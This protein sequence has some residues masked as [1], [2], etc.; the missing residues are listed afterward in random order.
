MT[1]CEGQT[2][3]ELI[4]QDV[5]TI[6]AM[7]GQLPRLAYMVHPVDMQAML[8]AQHSQAI[9]CKWYELHCDVGCI[10]VVKDANH[11]KGSTHRFTI[12]TCGAYFL[13]FGYKST[14]S[15]CDACSKP[16]APRC[17]QCGGYCEP[18][19]EA[20][21]ARHLK[22]SPPISYAKLLKRPWVHPVQYDPWAAY[23]G[24]DR[25]ADR[26]MLAGAVLAASPRPA[27][28][29]IIDEIMR[30][31]QELAAK[32]LPTEQGLLVAGMAD[33][34]REPTKMRSDATL[35]A[36]LGHLKH[37]PGGSGL[38]GPCDDGCPKCKSETDASRSMDVEKPIDP[39]DVEYD[40]VTLRELIRQ[41]TEN[42]RHDRL[43]M[44]GVSAWK[45]T[46]DQRAAVSAHWSAE[47]RAKVAASTAVEVQSNRRRI[48]CDP[49][50][51]I[52]LED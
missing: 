2:L 6:A 5:N 49:R 50:E 12:C 37:G 47:L 24:V 52:D 45:F 7:T 8:R 36:R 38:E 41:D 20:I 17:D 30:Q 9:D 1:P 51:A 29:F 26:E 3:E 21:A 16:T 22:C 27:G 14:R 42:I 33:A 44:T 19:L 13:G 15:E 18:G 39:L 10:R 23:A 4:R 35:S 11:P 32:A 31:Q 34:C 48:S 25:T 28:Q 40:G 43:T 46:T